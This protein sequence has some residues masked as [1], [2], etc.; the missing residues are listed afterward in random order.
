MKLWSPALATSDEAKL[1]FI[2]LYDELVA[3]RNL[4]G[5]SFAFQSAHFNKLFLL[6]EVTLF[7]VFGNGVWGSMAC[8]ARSNDELHLLH[9][10]NSS[11]GLRTN[12]SYV[13]MQYLLEYCL[14][15][16]ITLFLGGVPE[17][18]DGGVL[19]F[20]ERWTNSTRPSWLMRLIL[21]PDIYSDLMIPENK[22]FPAYR[23]NW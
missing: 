11:E 5:S 2:G 10:V 14:A 15:E 19:R 21:Q 20:K 16:D 6:P 1:A 7:G 4:S 18:D 22:F 3:R 13:L 12:S 8:A 23:K 17:G 9:I